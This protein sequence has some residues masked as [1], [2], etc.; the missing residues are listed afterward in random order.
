[1]KKELADRVLKGDVLAA[2]RLMRGIEDEVP[3]AVEAL[4]TLYSHAGRA[5]VIGITGAPGAGK[6]TLVGS[7]IGFFR[8]RRMTVGVIAIDPSSPFTG[9]AILGD[10]IRMQH[11][12]IDKDVFIRSLATRGTSGGLSKA[13]IST[14]R[15]MDAMGK[16]I[17][18]VETVGTGQA[19]VDIVKVSDTPVLVLTPGMGDE[20][21]MIKAGILE[22]AEIFVVNKE[23][24]GGADNVKRALEVMLDMKAYS[25]NTWKPSIVLTEAT[26]D[27]G[28]DKL[29]EEI[30]RHRQTLIDNGELEKR[31]RERLKLELIETIESSIKHYIY[32]EIGGSGYMEEFMENLI[33]RK[34]DPH[35]AA[36]EIVN[37]FTKKSETDIG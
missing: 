35:S 19:E 14:I 5:Y 26:C 18:L 31:R 30:L 1:M 10:R 2:A 21:Q 15:I 4:K 20:I 24:R 7:L 16:D 3:S 17:I 22:A 25:S 32:R 33:S 23:D 6:S 27:R 8:K 28:T 9:G 29:G 37:R 34:T 13:T 11:Y 36:A 12:N